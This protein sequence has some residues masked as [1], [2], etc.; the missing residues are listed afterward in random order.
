LQELADR[1]RPK[2]FLFPSLPCSAPY[3]ARGGVSV[4][5]IPPRIHLRLK[6]R[7]LR[8]GP[9]PVE[10]TLSPGLG[11]REFALDLFVVRGTGVTFHRCS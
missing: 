4:V 6:T 3:Y 9:L 7:F 11:V 8:L 1:A 5:S 10:D 2:G